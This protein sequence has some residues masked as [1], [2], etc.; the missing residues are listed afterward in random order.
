MQAVGAYKEQRAGC[1]KLPRFDVGNL[2]TLGSH[3]AV[4]LAQ[5]EVG[6]VGCGAEQRHGVVGW[7]C[8]DGVVPRVPGE[9]KMGERGRA[10]LGDG[11]MDCWLAGK[12]EK[13]MKERLQLLEEARPSD[14]RQVARSARQDTGLSKAMV[15]GDQ[16]AAA[17][18]GWKPTW[19]SPFP[20]SA[21]AP[22]PPVPGFPCWRISPPTQ[23][24]NEART[25]IM[26]L[27]PQPRAVM[28]LRHPAASRGA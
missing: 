20:S 25:I 17:T 22:C 23:A 16:M 15:C 3:E 18:N 11:G 6:E 19:P 7:W 8:G 14:G 5:G 26:N 13:G 1:S 24:N 10:G 2:A 21:A 27:H 4:D 28:T 9:T 12:N